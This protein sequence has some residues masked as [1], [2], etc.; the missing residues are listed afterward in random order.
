MAAKKGRQA[1]RGG[2]GAQK[3]AWLWVLVGMLLGIG[4]MLLVLARDWAP[5]LRRQNLPQPNPEAT[6]PRESEPPVAEVSELDRRALEAETMIMGLRLLTGVGVA[7]FAERCGRPLD[8]AYGPQLAELAGLGLLER[9]ERAARLTERG[10]MIG[11]EVF[12]RFL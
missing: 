12:L 3:P 5:L 7:H 9:D 4:L 2:N 6:A 10:R 1:T 8:E 11:N